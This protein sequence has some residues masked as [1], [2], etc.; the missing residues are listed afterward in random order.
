MTFSDFKLLEFTHDVPGFMVIN[1]D[2]IKIVKVNVIILNALQWVF[3]NKK[4]IESMKV[5]LKTRMN[6]NINLNW[7]FKALISSMDVSATILA[8]ARDINADMIIMGTKSSG[9]V[10]VK[11]RF[12]K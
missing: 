2:I 6:E 3:P 12:I 4:T 11:M 7:S 10:T 1:L 9:Q 8:Y 5:F